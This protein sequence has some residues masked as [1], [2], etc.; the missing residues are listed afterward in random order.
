[1]SSIVLAVPSWAEHAQ[2][3]GY[4]FRKSRQDFWR[5]SVLLHSMA[6]LIFHLLRSLESQVREFRLWGF[7]EFEPVP[8]RN[9]SQRRLPHPNRNG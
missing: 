3:L 2:R 5:L 8:R 4:A 9:R 6:L 7:D 1:M